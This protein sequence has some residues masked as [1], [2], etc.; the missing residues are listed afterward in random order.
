MDENLKFE[1]K[2]KFNFIY[3]LFMPLG[4]KLRRSLVIFILIIILDIITNI[5]ASKIDTQIFGVS[6]ISLLKIFY[7]IL[8]SIVTIKFFIDLVLKRM[9][10]KNMSYRFYETNL[11]YEDSFLN[12]QKKIIKY[13]NIKEVEIRRSVFDRIMGFGIIIISTNAEGGL[14]SGLIIYGIKNPNE[15][16]D[17]INEL[18][19]NVGKN[20]NNLAKDK[21]EN[22]S[23]IE[24]EVN[25]KIQV[26]EDVHQEIYTEESEKD[27]K[28]ELKNVNNE[29]EP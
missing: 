4:I 1:I 27:F 21:E 11:V 16:Y 13:E 15:I 26:A 3:E 18:V 12:Q 9:Q 29:N 22:E 7:L 19:H 17:R 8:L 28:D 10:Y 24:N 25:T 20:T 2:P 14:R 6:L 23:S 5:F